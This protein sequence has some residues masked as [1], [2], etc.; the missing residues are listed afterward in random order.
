MP[1]SRPC[2]IYREQL[3][4][5]DYGHALWEPSSVEGLY[6]RVT[7]GDVGYVMDGFFHRMFNV[8]LQWDD[9]SNQRHGVPP[10]RYEPLDIG[11]LPN[12]R[13]ETLTKG[14]YYS[15]NVRLQA[16]LDN[17][18]AMDSECSKCVTVMSLI[19]VPLTFFQC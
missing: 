12:V 9:P 18:S 6:D 11:P 14:C 5:L 2:D 3:I 19:D 10:Q 15:R 13:I 16:N 1:V 17:T 8:T 4:P 7:I